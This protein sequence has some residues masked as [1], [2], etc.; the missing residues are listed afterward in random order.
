MPDGLLCA[1]ETDQKIL[2]DN[3][4]KMC[5]MIVDKNLHDDAGVSTEIFGGRY[6][7]N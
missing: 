7:L 1:R 2:G 3:L 6:F 4:D 5:I